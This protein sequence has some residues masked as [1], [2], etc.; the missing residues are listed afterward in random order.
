MSDMTRILRIPTRSPPALPISDLGLFPLQVAAL[1]EFAGNVAEGVGPWGAR[2]GVFGLPCGAGKT[3]AGLLAPLVETTIDPSCT[4]PILYLVPSTLRS[5]WLAADVSARSGSI[6]AGSEL[7]GGWGAGLQ[8][9]DRA[10][11]F[12]SHEGLSS[13]TFEGWLEDHS[14]ATIIIDEAHRFGSPTSARWRRVARYL[15][16]HPTCRVVVMSGTLAGRSVSHFRHLLTAALRDYAPV[17]MDTREAEMW[18]AALDPHSDPSPADVAVMRPL[19]QWA[20]GLPPREAF[21]RRLTT[22]PGVVVGDEAATGSSLALGVMPLALPPGIAEATRRLGAEWVTPDGG[23][24]DS[25][26]EWARNDRTLP[27]GLWWRRISAPS[28][29]YAAV[30]G[31]FA[32]RVRQLIEYRGLYTSPG[33]ATKAVADALDRGTLPPAGFSWKDLTDY[34]WLRSRPAEAGEF[35]PEWVPFA[36]APAFHAAEAISAALYRGALHR[37][38][39]IPTVRRG[40]VSASVIS[41]VPSAIVWTLTPHL[42]RALAEALG[43]PY[44]GAGD[45]PPP[46]GLTVASIPVHGTGWDGAPRAGYSVSIVAEMPTSG[47]T[48][49]QLIARTHRYGAPPECQV[50]VIGTGANQRALVSAEAEAEYTSRVLGTRQR[51]QYADRISIGFG[52]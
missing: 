23:E 11:W 51:L 19:C 42:G 49:E 52:G 48:V 22:T 41:T 9:L 30:A 7:P 45:L 21:R 37:T 3:L 35:A 6:V 25:V 17:P 24:I 46:G 5:Q 47:A 44:R 31:R 40:G 29:E 39:E 43:V 28:V 4:G 10:A 15:R 38:A 13:V 27:Y 2:G 50:W 32:K 8:N 18:T 16:A 34:G 33:I 14:P 1:R 20:G 26:F 12:I 36:V